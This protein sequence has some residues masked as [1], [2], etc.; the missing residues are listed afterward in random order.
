MPTIAIRLKRFVQ[1]EKE[2]WN[3]LPLRTKTKVYAGLVGL[4]LANLLFTLFCLYTL[5]S[6]AVFLAAATLFIKLRVD[7]LLDRGIMS[8]FSKKT[9]KVLLERSIFDF[10]CDTWFMPKISLYLKAI[11][12][13]FFVAIEPE[14]AVHQFEDLPEAGQKLFLQKVL[15]FMVVL[16]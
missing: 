13:P 9:Q 4:A 7:A 1:Q 3:K 10:L 11:L 5:I 15:N 8:L 16:F 2:K 14:D 6:V 12:R